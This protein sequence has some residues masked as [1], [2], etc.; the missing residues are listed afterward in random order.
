[1]KVIGVGVLFQQF[2]RH[3]GIKVAVTNAAGPGPL[4]QYTPVGTSHWMP[5]IT[6]LWMNLN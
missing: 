2:F 1:M 6:Q 3:S 4:N 5:V